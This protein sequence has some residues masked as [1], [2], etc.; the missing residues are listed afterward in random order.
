MGR[1]ENNPD[2]HLVMVYHTSKM[3]GVKLDVT[4]SRPG[5]TAVLSL[6][7]LHLAKRPRAHALTRVSRPPQRPR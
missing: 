6:G 4:G 1:T 7:S 3:I 5:D 2:D